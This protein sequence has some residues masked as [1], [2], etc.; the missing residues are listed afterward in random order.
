MPNVIVVLQNGDIKLQPSQPKPQ[1]GWKETTIYSLQ[2]GAGQSPVTKVVTQSGEG[3]HPK[4]ST[5][6]SNQ[7]PG[8]SKLLSSHLEWLLAGA[9]GTQESTPGGDAVWPKEK[10]HYLSNVQPPPSDHV[11]LQPQVAFGSKTRK[12]N[13]DRLLF[14]AGSNRLAHKDPLSTMDGK[15]SLFF[16]LWLLPVPKWYFSHYWLDF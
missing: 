16:T 7:D 12:P 5:T 13:L 9:P 8:K 11:E 2:K 14:K 3:R 6:Y 4:L 15:V 1:Q 10:L